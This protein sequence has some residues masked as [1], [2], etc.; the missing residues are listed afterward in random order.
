M[1]E[2]STRQEDPV[3]GSGFEP[4]GEHLDIARQVTLD[5]V[6]GDYQGFHQSIAIRQE[7]ARRWIALTIVLLLA[8]IVVASFASLWLRGSTPVDDIV[9]VISAIIGPVIGIVGAVTGFYFSE[10]RNA[11][12]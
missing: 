2:Q 7:D 1:P 8:F 10:T 5:T 12:R 9:K 3:R 4:A 11:D 6:E